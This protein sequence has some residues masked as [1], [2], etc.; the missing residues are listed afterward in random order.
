ME[1]VPGPVTLSTKT[2]DGSSALLRDKNIGLVPSY[3]SLDKV[4]RRT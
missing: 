1:R 2:A 3:E 4:L